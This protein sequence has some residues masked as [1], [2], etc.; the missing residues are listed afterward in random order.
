[1]S[2][3]TLVWV[4]SALS[5]SQRA[6][7]GHGG[8]VELN[9]AP[10]GPYLLSV[11]TQP[12]PA[13]VGAWHIDIAVMGESGVPI[14]GATVRVRMEPLDSGATAPVEA[15][16][17]RDADPLGVRYRA[18]LTL[19]AAGPWQ[20]SVAVT[21]SAGSGSLAFPVDVEAA[22]RSWW[23]TGL[24]VAALVLLA[25]GAWRRWIAGTA[26]VLLL[27]TP[28]WPHASLVRSSPARRATLTTAPDRVQ[29]WFNEAIEPKFSRISVR[30]AAGRQADLGD[31]HFDPDE[32]QCLTIGLRALGRGTYH[33]RF[34]VLSVDG[35]VVESEF[36]FTLR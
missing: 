22:G 4:V 33:V 7:A 9:R 20:A 21:G 25:T 17:R 32:P 6:V 29:L 28:G 23:L 10:A 8:V 30:D 36:S 3:V 15:E 12:S 1:V 16:A 18:S 13:T 34:R 14:T 2:L 35:H 11:W 31:A 26:L 27:A 24:G 5:T 19:G